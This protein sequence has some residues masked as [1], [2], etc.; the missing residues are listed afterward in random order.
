MNKC[1]V[2][3]SR[4][5][6]YYVLKRLNLTHKIAT[7]KEE[8]KEDTVILAQDESRFVSE[9]NGVTSRKHYGDKPIAYLIDN[10][11]WHKTKKVKE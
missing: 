3:Y 2:K 10:A 11:S 1:K 5:G 7:C 9:S 6:V 8:L 4:N